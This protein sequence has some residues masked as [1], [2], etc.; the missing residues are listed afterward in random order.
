MA[1]VPLARSR[2]LRFPEVPWTNPARSSSRPA[3]AMAARIAS[4]RTALLSGSW[5]RRAHAQV[6]DR[7]GSRSQATGDL[8]VHEHAALGQAQARAGGQQAR[9]PQLGG[10]CASRVDSEG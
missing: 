4:S 5:E 8:A 10:G 7:G 1:T 9:R 3:S 6:K 2:T